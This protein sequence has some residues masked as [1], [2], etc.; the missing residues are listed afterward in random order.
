MVKSKAIHGVTQCS[1][2]LIVLWP[3]SSGANNGTFKPSHNLLG[4][5]K[6]RRYVL[7][8]GLGIIHWR[9]VKGAYHPL[10]LFPTFLLL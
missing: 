4:T 5:D 2:V 3:V 6:I 7:G 1:T 9:P 10:F 8:C